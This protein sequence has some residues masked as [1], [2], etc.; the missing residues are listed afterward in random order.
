[1]SLDPIVQ[2]RLTHVPFLCGDVPTEGKQCTKPELEGLPVDTVTT[3]TVETALTTPQVTH[4][5]DPHPA[6]ATAIVEPC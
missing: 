3:S 5:T 4:Q 6:P 2:W 1:M